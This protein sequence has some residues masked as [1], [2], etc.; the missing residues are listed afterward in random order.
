MSAEKLNFFPKTGA[1]GDDPT[2]PLR[3]SLR[4]PSQSASTG[5]L[6]PSKSSPKNTLSSS[7]LTTIPRFFR[8]IR[9]IHHVELCG[10]IAT[11]L[12][13][14]LKAGHAV[15]SYTWAYIDPDAHTATTHILARL[16]IRHSLLLP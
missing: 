2:P 16:H 9:P 5:K 10:G 3:K 12:E 7:A 6:R 11:R 4:D 15:A 13:A 8:P 14:I 1:L